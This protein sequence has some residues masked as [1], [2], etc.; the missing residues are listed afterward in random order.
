VNEL[1]RVEAQ[2]MREIAILSGGR[3]AMVGGALCLA[4]TARAQLLNRALPLGESVDV[5]AIRAW[6]GDHP[7]QVAVPAGYLGLD[8][9]LAAA[10]YR[11]DGAIAKH[12]R[13]AE[14]APPAATDLRIEETR[15]QGAYQLVL[16]EG[17]GAP[18]GVFPEPA[19]VGAPGFTCFLAWADDEPAAC[20]AL[21]VDGADGWV[22]VG[23][24]RPAF[25]GRG[26]QSALLGARIRR[27]RELGALRLASETDLDGVSRRNLE[28]AG[29]SP[30]YVREHWRS[31]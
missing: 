21:Y 1:E 23:A 25:R 7:H 19:F 31:S 16:R 4:H 20:G 11:R 2:A 10:G 6:Y 28:R 30:A 14:H 15:D 5:H 17:F 27:A 13:S 18:D 3:S 12:W 29:F 22:G 26:A 8:R 9:M 24:T